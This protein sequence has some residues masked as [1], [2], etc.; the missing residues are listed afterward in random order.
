MRKKYISG[1]TDFFDKS[2]RVERMAKELGLMKYIS[3]VYTNN[4]LSEK[5]EISSNKM[6][7]LR[8]YKQLFFNNYH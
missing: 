3:K 5:E 8:M 2:K 1:I 4:P 6:I 7:F